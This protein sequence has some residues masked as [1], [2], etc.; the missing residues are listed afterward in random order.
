YTPIF[1]FD[2]P[3]DALHVFKHIA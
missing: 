3:E 1:C 2:Q